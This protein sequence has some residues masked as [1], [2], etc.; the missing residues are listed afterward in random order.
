MRF[1]EHA[2]C[3]VCTLSWPLVSPYLFS[4]LAGQPWLFWGI[5]LGVAFA[6]YSSRQHVDMHGP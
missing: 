2:T 4:K 3:L 6:A 1:S 5:P